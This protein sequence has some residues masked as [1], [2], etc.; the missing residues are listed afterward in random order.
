MLRAVTP[1]PPPPPPAEK[2]DL[3]LDGIYEQQTNVVIAG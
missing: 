3:Q 1:P 2:G